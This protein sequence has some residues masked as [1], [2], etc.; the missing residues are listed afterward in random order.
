LLRCALLAAPAVALAFGLYSWVGLRDSSLLSRAFGVSLAGLGGA[1]YIAL[2]VAT[3][4]RESEL[5]VQVTRQFLGRF[6]KRG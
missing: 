3:H 1:V 4:T 2:A 6:S 5:V